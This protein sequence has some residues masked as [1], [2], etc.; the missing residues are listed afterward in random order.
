MCAGVSEVT[1]GLEIRKDDPDWVKLEEY[2]R[3]LGSQ[4]VAKRLG[5]L[6]ELY[7]LGTPQ[8]LAGLQKLVAPSYALL[9]PLL[10][11]SGRYL[12][13]WRL[14]LNIDPEILKRIAST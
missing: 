10:P 7:G 8:I 6:L 3:R 1:T 4:V 9:G 13:R 12:S 2:A 14:H 11:A 5:Y